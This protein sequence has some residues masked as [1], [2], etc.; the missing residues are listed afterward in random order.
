MVS[1]SIWSVW[2][3]RAAI[4]SIPS[5]RHGIFSLCES[6]WRSKYCSDGQHVLF[7]S[8]R[9]SGTSA[10]GSQKEDY[11]PGSGVVYLGAERGAISVRGEGTHGFL[12]NLVTQ[13]TSLLSESNPSVYCH[14][15]NSKG[16]FL[17]DVFLH[18]M[19]QDHIVVDVAQQRKD[20]LVKMLKM[21]SL[22]SGVRIQD[23]SDRLHVMARFGDSGGGF[24]EDARLGSI[25]GYRGVSVD[26]IKSSEDDRVIP[27]SEYTK[28]RLSLGV[29]EGPDEIPEGSVPLEYNLDGLNGISFSKGCYIGQEL[30]ARTHYQGQIRKRIMPFRMN[31]GEHISPGDDIIDAESKKKVGTVRS[32]CVDGFG[33]GLMRTASVLRDENTTVDNLQLE[34]SGAP[35]K[36]FIPS[37]WPPSYLN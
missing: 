13:D 35:I 4:A 5:S 25:L 6:A 1:S 8:D 31:T 22:R 15:L 9:I 34:S 16:R 17:Y 23:D 28:L 30:M 32:M 27:V 2:R 36:P 7:H 10:D 20:S 3:A 24:S 18:R 19:A 29:A 11:M 21:Y 33:L 26:T 37:W 12:Q 14:M